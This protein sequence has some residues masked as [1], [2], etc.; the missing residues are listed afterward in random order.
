MMARISVIRSGQILMSRQGAE[1][2]EL[3][4]TEEW[5]QGDSIL[6]ESD[7][8]YNV[9]QVDQVVL[10]ARVY[11]P[12]KRMTYRL[13]LKGDDP[14]VYPPFAFKGKAHL[15]RMRPDPCREYRNL[16][17]NPADQR[18]DTDAFP[19]A[20][21]NIETRNESVFCARNVIDGLHISSGHGYWPYQ[22]WGV[23]TEGDPRL[24]VDFG[25]EVEIDRVVLYLRSDF[26]HDA[27]WDKA[28]LA[29]SDG[30]KVNIYPEGKEGAQVFPVGTRR[31][32]W[33]R[34]E[35]LRKSSDP[36]PFPALRQMEVY[37]RD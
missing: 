2:A 14:D 31:I 37:G 22:S 32:K 7:M 10:P 29:F 3:L 5:Q 27:W 35:G 28:V 11:L 13:P 20:T 6:F 30:E 34:L 19:H 25:R 21:A 24:T 18:G 33:V 15:I 16:A 36:S 8:E 12:G 23:E 17:E 1:E 9:I 4:F 26:P